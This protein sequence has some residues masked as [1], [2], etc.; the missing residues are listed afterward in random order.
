M[1]T[2]IIQIISTILAVKGFIAGDFSLYPYIALAF[3][4]CDILGFISG[5]LKS[6]GIVSTVVWCAVFCFAFKSF[7]IYTISIAYVAK[8]VLYVA[9][10]LVMMLISPILSLFIKK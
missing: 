3:L 9:F 6:L 5:Q 7:D 8:Q 1:L 2:F 10:T 4:V